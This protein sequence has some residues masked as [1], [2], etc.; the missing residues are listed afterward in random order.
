M[1]STL[2][3]VR[4]D[5]ALLCCLTSN[6]DCGHLFLSRGFM[7]LSFRNYSSS[8]LCLFSY[9]CFYCS[10]VCNRPPTLGF[11][12]SFPFVTFKLLLEVFGRACDRFSTLCFKRHFLLR[13]FRDVLIMLIVLF[14]DVCRLRILC[15]KIRLLLISFRICFL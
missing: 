13:Y 3:S 10:N 12:C 9:L 7:F 14:C 5:L 15:L 4:N 2:T 1:V 6:K 11:P 8:K